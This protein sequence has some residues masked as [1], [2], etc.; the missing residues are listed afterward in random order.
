MENYFLKYSFFA[1]IVEIIYPLCLMTIV[2]TLK[3]NYITGPKIL[4]N[5]DVQDIL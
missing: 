1:K 3:I 5:K 4:E 2:V